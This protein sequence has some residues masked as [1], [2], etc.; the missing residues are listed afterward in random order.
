M[1]LLFRKSRVCG[2]ALAFAGLVLFFQNCAAPV[3]FNSLEANGSSNTSS[4]NQTPKYFFTYQSFDAYQD[5]M[6]FGSKDSKNLDGGTQVLCKGNYAQSTSLDQAA[7]LDSRKTDGMIVKYFNDGK[8]IAVV[9]RVY[10]VGIDINSRKYY[11]W[12]L[13]QNCQKVSGPFIVQGDREYRSIAS[14]GDT[15]ILA[16]RDKVNYGKVELNI[17]KNFSLY[18]T[19][20]YFNDTSCSNDLMLTSLDNGNFLFSCQGGQNDPL[21]ISLMDSEGS[22]IG[23]IKNVDGTAGHSSFYQSYSVG[24]NHSGTIG[25]V[26]VSLSDLSIHLAT[27]DTNLNLM[28]SVV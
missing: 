21:K 19:I 20:D 2:V 3:M 1:K 24:F 27:Y 23:A 7:Y 17:F 14:Y 26:W 8:N 11:V 4:N 10:E 18:K 6:A 22:M 16:V 9:S 12:F 13:D 28:N 5:Q 25:V 15:V